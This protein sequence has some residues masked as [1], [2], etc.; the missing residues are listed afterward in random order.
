VRR[1]PTSSSAPGAARSSAPRRSR[2]G[3]AGRT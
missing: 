1:N 2:P 3:R